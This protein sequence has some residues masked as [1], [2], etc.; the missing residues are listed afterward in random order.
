MVMPEGNLVAPVERM[1]RALEPL[2]AASSVRAVLEEV[3]RSAVSVLAA[4]QGSVGWL[5]ADGTLR[6]CATPGLPEEAA[7][8][9]V[10]LLLG[11]PM[12]SP[13][14]PRP[15]V[16]EDIGADELLKGEPLLP[17]RL[18]MKSLVAL[19]LFLADG[20]RVGV[21]VGWFRGTHLPKEEEVRHAG[22]YA[23]LAGIALGRERMMEERQRAIAQARAETVQAEV[24]RLTRY[25]AVTEGFSRALTRREVARVVL[26]LGLPAVG[27]AAGVVHLLAPDGRDVE[28]AAAVGLEP[29]LEEALQRLPRD[30]NMPGYD[31]ART[32]APVWLES[33]QEIGAR[34]PELAA[35]PGMAAYQAFAFLPVL[36]EGKV[37]GVIT[38][39][40]D[41]PRRFCMPEQTCILGLA[42]QCGLALERSLLYEREHA[43][44]LQEEAAAQRL[45]VLADASA[46]LSRSLEWEE[47]VEGVARLAVG[48]FA[49]LCAV[50]TLEGEGVRRLAILHVDPAKAELIQQMKELQPDPACSAI[51]EA[52][53]AGRPILE[54][55]VTPERVAQRT[56]DTRARRIAQELE[57]H[58]FITTPLVA[59]GRILGALSFVRGGER[60]PY[61]AEDLALAE[62]LAS[63]AALAMDNAR[64]FQ[65]RRAAEEESR[66]SATRL[67]LLVSVSQLLSEA[68]LDLEQVLEVLGRAVTQEVGDGCL[69]QLVSED[70][71]NL[72]LVA[73][74]HPEPKARALLELVAR[75]RRLRVGEGLQGAAV[76]TG[77]TLFLREMTAEALEGVGPEAALRSYFEQRGPQDVIAVPL[78]ARGRS[79]GSLLVVRNSRGRPYGQDD[80][81]LL[82]TIASRAALAIEDAR[83]YAA[84]LQALRLRDDFLSVAGH[85]LKNPLNAL[86]LQLRVLARKAREQQLSESLAERADR[87][88]RIGERLGLL[89]EDLLDVSRITAGQLQLQYSEVD[90]SAVAREVIS[91]MDEE[92]SR[93]GCETLLEAERPVVGCW[94]RLRLEQVLM[95]LL[96]NACKYGRKQPVRVRVEAAPGVARLSV[97]DEGYGIAPEDQERIFQRFQRADATRH[98][99]GLGLGLWICRQIA[100]AHGGTL[101][102]Q[103]EPGKG[104]TFILELP[105]GE[106]GS[107]SAP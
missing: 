60:P 8:A 96:S 66:R 5:E 25:Q 79:C 78:V 85:E 14:Y 64:L 92:L 107:A 29:R 12:G 81:V 49:D 97:Q 35:K 26:Q 32:R 69:L 3:V 86:Q 13:E 68:G 59:R 27:A 17:G 91:R 70:G 57:V 11:E 77:Q 75:V 51:T 74:H 99:Q 41:A 31:A 16:A 65:Q 90:L 42:R 34:Y 94:D 72:E 46:L 52:L 76:S 53:R 47:T 10:A 1:A 103:S 30:G 88:A 39:A 67:H 20:A 33:P 62:D 36:T 105:H 43:A 56:I 37:L 101:R 98:I 18:G 22:V 21:L 2:A 61:T 9:C 100:E 15:R 71:Q 58:S 48:R 80:Q 19:P 40:F 4:D 102:V 82:E 95:N 44:R 87:V 63:R 89:I 54:A 104:S 106:P 7:T 50:D 6:I 38:F 45:R 23:R 28:L 55:Q 84:A 83:L 24:Q 73:V 93:S